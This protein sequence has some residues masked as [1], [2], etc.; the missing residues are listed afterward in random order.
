MADDTSQGDTIPEYLTRRQSQ[1][2]IIGMGPSRMNE[3]TSENEKSAL[4][5]TDHGIL[6]ILFHNYKQFLPLEMWFSTAAIARSLSR[7]PAYI[8]ERVDILEKEYGLIERADQARNTQIRLTTIGAAV[9]EGKMRVSDAREWHHQEEF[10]YDE[11]SLE[12]TVERAVHRE[13]KVFMNWFE[14]EWSQAKEEFKQLHQKENNRIV[15]ENLERYNISRKEN[16]NLNA[17]ERGEQFDLFKGEILDLMKKQM[18]ADREFYNTQN[19]GLLKESREEIL[20]VL[21]S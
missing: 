20:T 15:T 14:D 1:I 4:T 2:N 19:A 18:Q 8:K 16:R 21:Q 3:R 12:N 7:T 5:P 9:M 17:K 10:N 11:L 6:H 13:L